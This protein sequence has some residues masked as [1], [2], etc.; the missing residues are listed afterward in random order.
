MLGCAALAALAVG[1]AACG[2]NNSSTASGSDPG[3]FVAEVNGDV[4]GGRFDDAFELL[5]PAQKRIVGS[6]DRLERCLTGEVP[7]YPDGARYVTRETRVQPWP[8]PGTGERASSTAVTVEVRGGSPERVV[9]R[10]TQHVFR[11]GGKWTWIL[12]APLVKAARTGA[13]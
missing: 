7:D 3:A 5:H 2:G 10:F 13:C 6:A 9:D 11:V 4:L 12:S 8:I 1:A